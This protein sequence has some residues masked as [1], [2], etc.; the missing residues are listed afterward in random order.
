MLT[1]QRARGELVVTLKSR[2][3][4]TV[5]DDLRQDG[6]MKARFPRPVDWMEVT[7]LNASG[8]VA[9]GDRLSTSL[10][11]RSGARTTFTAQAAERFYRALPGD[12]PATV[13]TRILVE[14]AAEWLPQESILFDR[15]A[16]DRRLEVD[17][18]PGAWFLGLE[19]LVFGRTAMGEVVH[20]ARLRDTIRIRQGGRL[21][22]HDAIRMEG[23]VAETMA[24][25]ATGNGAAAIATIILVAPDAA[26]HLD[27]LR[28]ALAGHQAG[29]SA[30]DG[31][32]VARIVAQDG[33][34]I[35]AAIVAGLPALRDGR[36][37]PRV[38]NC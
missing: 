17:V 31:M 21:T 32:L 7:T 8:G 15:C 35:R 16:F 26:A 25:P 22:L 18:A 20:H 9:G 37:L 6:C 11:V 23:P 38:W 3:G 30:W 33:A 2:D 4:T 28:D 24:R 1:Y 29:V 27:Q 13:R 10:R 14:G 19:T 36:A 34:C 5:L 12:P